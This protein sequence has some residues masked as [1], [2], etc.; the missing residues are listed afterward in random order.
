MMAF[1]VPCIS[2]VICYARIFCIVRMTA[3]RSHDSAGALGTNI[4]MHIRSAAANG[5]GQPTAKKLFVSD[6][7]RK[8]SDGTDVQLLPKAGNGSITPN[9]IGRRCVNGKSLP[10]SDISSTVSS[11]HSHS[12]LKSSLK[13][14]DIS[15][16]SD[17]PPTLSALRKHTLTEKKLSGG[18]RISSNVSICRTVEYID[19]NGERRTS[20]DRDCFVKGMAHDNDSAVEESTSS[21]E[22]NQVNLFAKSQAHQSDSKLLRCRYRYTTLKVIAIVCKCCLF[23]WNRLRVPA[24][25]CPWTPT[26]TAHQGNIHLCE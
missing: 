16:E 22:N 26:A 10:D 13:F 24:S 12:D 18:D 17:F 23:K 4:S 14:I 1:V 2:I 15:I 3:M 19:G 9:A 11:S 25:I 7:K 6:N 8:R 5:K 21:G 20:F